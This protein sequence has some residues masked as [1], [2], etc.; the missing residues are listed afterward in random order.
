LDSEA[1]ER[2][3]LTLLLTHQQEQL[4][5]RTENVQVEKESEGEFLMEKNI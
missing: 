3:K 1:K 5:N 4:F 2:R